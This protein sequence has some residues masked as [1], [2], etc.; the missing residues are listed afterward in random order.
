MISRKTAVT[1][2][3][4]S[5]SLVRSENPVD[6]VGLPVVALPVVGLPLAGLA[7]VGLPLV[8]CWPSGGLAV[9]AL[10]ARA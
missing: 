7:A 4:S 8:G 6:P 5:R 3:W 10:P 9:L 2:I 1:A